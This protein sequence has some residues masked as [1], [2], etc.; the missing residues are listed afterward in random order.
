[1]AH[2]RPLAPNAGLRDGAKGDQSRPDGNILGM[3]G[4]GPWGRKGIDTP[5]GMKTGLGGGGTQQA[6]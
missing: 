5:F 1:M 2:L 6:D 4:V 3:K